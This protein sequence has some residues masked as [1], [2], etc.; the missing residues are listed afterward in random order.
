MFA[1]G[2]GV[3]KV[4]LNL[5]TISSS[6]SV[7]WIRDVKTELY[8]IDIY[9]LEW[10]INGYHHYRPESILKFVTTLDWSNDFFSKLSHHAIF[11]RCKGWARRW[12]KVLKNS[13]WFP[14]MTKL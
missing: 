2:Y 6:C 14:E 1:A 13:A 8:K 9:N 11:T 10:L 3:Q 7:D 12:A 4:L 5:A